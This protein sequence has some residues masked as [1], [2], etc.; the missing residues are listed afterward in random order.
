MVPSCWEGAAEPWYLPTS[1]AVFAF[2]GVFSRGLGVVMLLW[3][4]PVFLVV[5]LEIKLSPQ[6]YL[7]TIC[8][9]HVRTQ[10]GFAYD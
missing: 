8:R 4:S 9:E 1:G 5:V 6:S 3:R 10:L 7:T 2:A